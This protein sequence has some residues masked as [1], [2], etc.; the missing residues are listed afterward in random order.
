MKNEI[1]SIKRKV[2]NGN[3][4]QLIPFDGKN[5]VKS[6]KANSFTQLYWLIWRAYLGIVRNPMETRTATFQALFLATVFGLSY[7]QLEISQ[8][9]VQNI[10]AILFMIWNNSTFPNMI[11][12][13]STLPLEIPIFLREYKNQMYHVVNYYLSKFIIEVKNMI[14]LKFPK[15]QKPLKLYIFA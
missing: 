4:D 5:R 3:Q 6:H 8:K 10:N 7:L 14:F 13:V 2:A 12:V 9:G 15:T 11:A 1:E